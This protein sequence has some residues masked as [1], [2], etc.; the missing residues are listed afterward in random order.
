VAMELRT[1]LEE[2][3]AAIVKLAAD[4]MVWFLDINRFFLDDE[5]NLPVSVMPDLLHPNELGYTIWANAMEPKIAELLGEAPKGFVPLFN[6]TDLRGWKGLVANPEKRA[7]MT[8]KELAKAQAAAD[9]NMERH[10]RIVDG[11]LCFDGKGRSLC[12]ARDYEDFEMLVDWKIEAGGDSGIYLRGAPQ[13][14]I[15]DPAQWPVGSGGLY[16][17]QKNPKDPVV[18]ADNPILAWNRFRITMVGEK[19]TVYLNDLLVVDNTVLENYWNRDIPIY[20]HGQIELQSHGSILWFK[21]VFVREI[22][23]G[24]GWRPLFNGKDLS[25][26]EQVGGE[27]MTWGVENGQLYTDGDGGGWL[28]TTEEYGDFEIELEF[29]VPENGNSGVFIRAPREGNP[30]FEGSEVQ[31]LDDYGSEYTALDPG[32]YAGSLYKWAAPSRRATLEPGE[33]QKMRIL[34]Q[35]KHIAVTLNCWPIVDTDWEDQEPHVQTN[36]GLKRDK[37]YIGLQNHG[38]RLDYRNIRIRTF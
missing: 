11:A 8:P 24:E 20:G 10:W 36:P 5:R 35:G 12:T 2:V 26:W 1:K 4:E 22:P 33:W 7:K 13:V 3:N 28:S 30:A 37:G 14:T 29:R 34:C 19:V 23:R 38:S 18:C 27:R 9:R 6:G 32:Q 21:N 25:G 31:V 17:N 15:W 16:N